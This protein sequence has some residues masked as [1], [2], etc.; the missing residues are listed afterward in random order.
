MRRRVL[1]TLAAGVVALG[2]GC[3]GDDMTRFEAN[4]IAFEH[5]SDWERVADV[6]EQDRDKG[7]VVALQG[8]SDVDGAP[9]RVVAFNQPR[10]PGTL[11][12]YGKEV[13]ATRPQQAGGP[14][15]ED[16]K[17]DVPGAEGAW[18]VVVDYRVRPED[19]GEPVPARSIDLLPVEGDRQYRLTITGPREAIEAPDI[20][21]L[22]DSFEITSNPT[23]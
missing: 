15:V 10:E 4:G 11:A 20:D 1:T 16:G 2:A 17:V 19:G 8:D 9:V 22:I 23:A 3:G 12:Q 7:L 13:A 21:E 6:E 14:L 18:R 5:P